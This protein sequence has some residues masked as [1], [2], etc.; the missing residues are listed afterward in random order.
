MT[1]L[2]RLTL[3]LWLGLAGL[4][5][6]TSDLP[7]HTVTAQ[8]LFDEV[9]YEL[10]LN[11]GGP[12]GV[13]AQ[14]LREEYWPQLQRLCEGRSVCESQRAYPLID[15]MLAELHDHHTNFYTPD[16]WEEI[17]LA[18]SGETNVLSFG[19]SLR[20]IDG[21]GVL[22]T[23]VVPKSPAADAGLRAGDLIT[24]LGRL[25]LQGEL[26]LYKL[27]SAESSGRPASITYSR[28]GAAAQ[29]LV[30]TGALV[31]PPA[32]SF[33]MLD[34]RTA[35]LR[36]RHFDTTGVA[37]DLHNALRRAGQQGAVRA[38]L[39]LRGN[40]GGWID[41]A[42]LSMGALRQPEPLREKG[43]VTTDIM[44]YTEGRYLEDGQQ[45][46]RVY[47]AQRFTGPL[48]VL[49]DEDSASSAEFMAR[50]L[51]ARPQTVV[52]G[53]PTAGV[54]NSVT[55][56][57]ELADGSSLQ[58]T[59]STLQDANGTVLAD[60]IQPDILIK[61]DDRAFART[62]HDPELAAALAT[63]DKLEH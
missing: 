40:S 56:I 51:L 22:V 8:D 44:T 4:A 1:T 24:Q 50:D 13:R 55:R 19:T 12:A 47:K 23:E 28:A 48:A 39:D 2:K 18:S 3:T 32:I 10:A 20:L 9:I 57:L 34:D 27:Y 59:V 37:Q 53:R 54:A 30:L 29:A 41:E 49:V 25:P 63:L 46:A 26:G 42:V 62:G 21:E 58:V 33:E 38:V 16:I 61:Q 14:D 43:R 7:A 36:L 35:L 5:A 15:Q 60:K 52:L 31:A 11:Y 45:L 6:A 17:N